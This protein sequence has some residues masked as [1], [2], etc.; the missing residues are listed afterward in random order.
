MKIPQYT[1]RFKRT[2]IIHRVYPTSQRKEA[3][4]LRYHWGEGGWWGLAGVEVIMIT[5]PPAHQRIWLP[6][7]H[8]ACSL[9]SGFTEVQLSVASAVKD[10]FHLH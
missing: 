2:E 1:L 8:V 10:S 3:I 4:T 5:F 7:A 9:P 6:T